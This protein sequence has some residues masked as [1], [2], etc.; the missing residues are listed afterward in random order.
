MVGTTRVQIRIAAG[1]LPLLAVVGCLGQVPSNPS[2]ADG[3]CGS[4]A[5]P[6]SADLASSPSD[7]AGVEAQDLAP[8]T[9]SDMAT[10]PQTSNC[11]NGTCFCVGPVA[12]GNG[13]GSDWNNQ[14]AW[15]S[16]P[17]RGDTW[18]LRGGAYASKTFNTPDSGSTLITIKKASA[19]DHVT[20][21]GWQASYGTD[22]AAW[23]SSAVIFTSGHY[24]FD[25]GYR[26]EDDWFDGTA[27]GFGFTNLNWGSSVVFYGGISNVTVRYCY[28]KGG[29]MTSS[30]PPVAGFAFDAH[31]GPLNYDLT[32]SR[33][34]SE[35]G[36]DTFEFQQ[37]ARA[38]IEYCAVWGAQGSANNHGNAIDLFYSQYGST[39]RYNI[40]RDSYNGGYPG[41]LA[42]G[43][44]SP[45]SYSWASAT[46]GQTLIYG[47]VID[48]YSGQGIETAPPGSA[49]GTGGHGRNVLVYNNTIVSRPGDTSYD[50]ITLDWDSTL[51]DISGSQIY[52]N[53]IVSNTTWGTAIAGVAD[54]QNNV[55]T[56]D[57]SIF[58]NY[59]NRDLRLARA[60]GAGK[61]LSAPYNADLNEKVRGADGVFDV[62]AYEY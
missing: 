42:G 19:Q 32:I 6:P 11:T 10:T 36:Y 4:C 8:T 24:V 3:G 26:N 52:N 56:S 55:V 14:K 53:L 15:S 54:K 41:S 18:Y 50:A 61:P 47:N 48:G 37:A 62:G 46:S 59:A 39:V 60:V 13:S 28:S 25:G 57:T 40:L 51:G 38:V 45:F 2:N 35:A 43:A 22:Q 58:V 12:T 1:L 17:A 16:T 27:Y 33:C 29:L 20:N 5:T 21:T 9:A 49:W 34:Y 44:S 31:E 30:T 23:T 7:L